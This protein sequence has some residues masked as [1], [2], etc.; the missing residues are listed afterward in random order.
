MVREELP[1]AL[2]R[3]SFQPE[4]TALQGTIARSSEALLLA[5]EDPEEGWGEELA[6]LYV[7]TIGI[8][9]SSLSRF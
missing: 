7:P 1:T 9:R 2:G 4:H 5:I 6:Q 8:F 3:E